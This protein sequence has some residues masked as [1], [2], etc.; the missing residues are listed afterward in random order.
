VESSPAKRILVV[1]NR[2]ASTPRLL[3]ELARRA[4]AEPT[5]FTLLIPDVRDRKAADWT[6][7]TALP[8]IERSARGEVQ[9]LA[10]GPDPFESVRDAVREGNFDE[11]IISTLPKRVSKWLRRDLIRRVQGLGIP[12]TAIVPRMAGDASIDAS[13]EAGMG[14]AGR[15]MTAGQD[16]APK[17]SNVRGSGMST[18]VVSSGVAAALRQIRES[19]V[20]RAGDCSSPEAT[21]DSNR[22]PT[23]SS[24]CV[25]AL[26]RAAGS[27]TRSTAPQPA[28]ARVAVLSAGNWAPA[29]NRFNAG[30]APSRSADRPISP[31]TAQRKRTGW[32]SASRKRSSA[33]R[34]RCLAMPARSHAG[35][36][37]SVRTARVRRAANRSRAVRLA[38]RA[39]QRPTGSAGESAAEMSSPARQRPAGRET[40]QGPPRV[41][42]ATQTGLPPAPSTSRSVRRRPVAISC[43][44]DGSEG[45]RTTRGST[46]ESP[47]PAS[48]D[49]DPHSSTLPAGEGR[50]NLGVRAH[51]RARGS[52]GL[53]RGAC[54]WRADPRRSGA[55]SPAL[56]PEKPLDASYRLEARGEAR[57]SR[58]QTAPARRLRKRRP[59]EGTRRDLSARPRSAD[60]N[61]ATGRAS[62]RGCSSTMAGAVERV[63][64][65]P[66]SHVD[67]EP[68]RPQRGPQDSQ[69]TCIDEL[70]SGQILFE[71]VQVNG[72][73]VGR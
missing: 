15:A 61:A 8:L 71:S 22:H 44:Y 32:V 23:S 40:E 43:I 39:R 57:A 10:G 51:N 47:S 12:V 7:A 52:R 1:A 4:K 31:A 13:L 58:R 3:D 68:Y 49:G 5:E 53:A 59:C 65:T 36:V 2:T 6:L 35:G 70:G 64:R 50:G 30:P 16:W 33:L 37:P 38:A 18:R 69:T 34:L 11:I 28:D 66:A 55:S 19:R 56:R 27:G 29:W 73:W 14:A 24:R 45:E 48:S 21:A 67:V 9:G 42:R 60:A 72:G 26:G 25:R 62:L 63:A 17:G 41:H 20:A 54:H 46:S